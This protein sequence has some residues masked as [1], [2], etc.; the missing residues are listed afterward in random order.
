MTTFKKYVRQ[1]KFA[2]TPGIA[3]TSTL[4][5]MKNAQGLQN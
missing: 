2:T 5:I 1:I 3:I 4:I